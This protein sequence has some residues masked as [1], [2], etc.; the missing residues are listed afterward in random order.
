MSGSIGS[1]QSHLNDQKTGLQGSSITFP[2][3]WE[4]S[5]TLAYIQLGSILGIEAEKEGGRGLPK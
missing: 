1:S 2:S 5:E 3:N 4:R